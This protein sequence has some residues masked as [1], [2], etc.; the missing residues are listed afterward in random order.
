[1]SLLRVY[2]GISIVI[3]SGSSVAL[4]LTEDP[5]EQIRR[6]AHEYFSLYIKHSAES[7]DLPRH[8]SQTSQQIVRDFKEALERADLSTLTSSDIEDILL[9]VSDFVRNDQPS[10]IPEMTRLAETLVKRRDVSPKVAQVLH[11]TYVYQRNWK[12]AARWGEYPQVTELNGWRQLA[13]LPMAQPDNLA[14][15]GHRRLV[16]RDDTSLLSVRTESLSTFSGFVVIQDPSCPFSRAASEQISSSALSDKLAE[17]S[18][19]MLPQN[20]PFDRVGRLAWFGERIGESVQ[21]FDA[22]EW[23]EIGY[24]GTPSFYVFK[25]GA[26]VGR[27]FGWHPDHRERNLSKL[28]EL[29]ELI[30]PEE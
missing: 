8:Q 23:P 7:A 5:S 18:L 3:I 25:D 10:L 22:A 30:D 26:V 29:V 15:P 17:R 19:L 12:A 20:K 13:S 21:T 2:L 28:E 24:W 27:M 14:P 1:M 4:P 11:Q 16:T 9:T 6:D